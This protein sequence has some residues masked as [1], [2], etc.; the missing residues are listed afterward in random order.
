VILSIKQ[1]RALDYL[2][3]QVTRELLFG[4]GAGGGK[5]MLGCYWQLKRRIKYPGTRGLIGRASLKTLKETT[6]MSFFDVCKRQGIVP[7]RDLVYNQQQSQIHFSNG[8][9]IF[10][11]DLFL[12][13]SDPEFD[14]L[15]SLEI[16]DAFI[17]ECNQVVEKGWNVVR[18]RIRWML[19]EYGLVPK[20]MGSCNPAK[21]FVYSRFYKPDKDGTLPA[22][23]KFIQCLAQENPNI[24]KYYIENLMGLDAASRARLLDGL[25]EYDGDPAIMIIYDKI[26]EAF[27]NIHLASKD[28]RV[29]KLSVDVARFGKDKTT[30]GNWYSPQHVMIE[31]HRGL[32]TSQTADLIN[33]KREKYDIAANNIV[34]DEDGV[35]GGVVDQVPG[36]KGFI[37]N[38]K[39]YQDPDKPK[40]D[41]KTGAPLPGY[42]KNLK[43]QCAYYLAKRFNS[44]SIYI[45]CNDVEVRNKITEEVDKI[46]RADIDKDGPFAI[47]SKEKV[48]EMISRSPD[49]SDNLLMAE[50]VEIRPNSGLFAATI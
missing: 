21:N 43:S 40:Y 6:L 48:K 34:I 47:I 15:G 23:R 18:S 16:T 31:T 35:G 8:S 42:Y 33:Y 20:M 46:R 5:S 10:L 41:P 12:Y 36:S 50:E 1:T 32:S 22:D 11:K 27:Q 24:S 13:P 14:E 19:D 9:L 25:W 17:D 2:E 26:V 38:S 44:G 7:G 4:G 45:E 3:D 39:P 37:N 28:R 49:Y 30:I 29:R